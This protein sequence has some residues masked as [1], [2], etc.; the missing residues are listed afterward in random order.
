MV[1]APEAWEYPKPGTE[2]EKDAARAAEAQ[3]ALQ[4]STEPGAASSGDDKATHAKNNCD[5]KHGTLVHWHAPRCI[6]IASISRQSANQKPV[7]SSSQLTR[8]IVSAEGR[9]DLL[10]R[11]PG[12]HMGT[13]QHY[14]YLAAQLPFV[15]GTAQE[16]I[17]PMRQGPLPWVGLS[18]LALCRQS[19]RI[20]LL[21]AVIRYVMTTALCL[22]RHCVLPCAHVVRG[23]SPLQLSLA[24]L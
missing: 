24:L 4:A 9:A 14:H 1:D 10:P 18:F 11:Y 7:L 22:K 2:D 23:T 8:E 19:L 21:T 20:A 16:Y 15:T 13:Y 17:D 3:E 5:Y 12:A 6:H